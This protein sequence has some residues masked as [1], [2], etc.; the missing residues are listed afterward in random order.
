M[1]T[2]AEPQSVMVERNIAEWVPEI[3]AVSERSIR[4]PRTYTKARTNPDGTTEEMSITVGYVEGLG[5]LTLQDYEV[6]LLL[7]KIWQDNEFLPSPA[8]LHDL[9]KA[10]A[11][12]MA[13]CFQ[14]VDFAQ[15][16]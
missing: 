10:V 4:G 13:G 1:R 3:F 5:T 9:A 14:Q 7:H 12:G 2:R 16:Y 15:A 11:K 6:L 8:L